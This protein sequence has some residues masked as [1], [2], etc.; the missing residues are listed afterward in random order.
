[1]VEETYDRMFTVMSRVRFSVTKE[2]DGVPVDCI[3]DHPAAKDLQAQRHLEVFCE[4]TP[5]STAL[6]QGWRR[7]R[8]RRILFLPLPA[9]SGVEEQGWGR[10]RR[11][12]NSPSV[13]GCLVV[14][15][16]SVCVCVWV[17]VVV[18]VQVKAGVEVEEEG[19]FSFSAGLFCVLVAIWMVSGGV[20]AGGRSHHPD[21]DVCMDVCVWVVEV[22]MEVWGGG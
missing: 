19:E 9:P 18:E 4:W 8:R 21:V 20:V 10:R 5:P 14:A 1:M 12:E 13:P 6:H 11:M 15:I 16:W 17:W 2:D 3:V 22:E 7:R